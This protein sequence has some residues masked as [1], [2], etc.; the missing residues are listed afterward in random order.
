M[1]VGYSITALG[2][3]LFFGPLSVVTSFEGA[4]DKQR[5]RLVRLL[6]GVGGS[7]L[8]ISL[9]YVVLCFVLLLHV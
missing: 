1:K 9:T 2:F 8:L 4:L 6:R 3:I 5:H 7:A